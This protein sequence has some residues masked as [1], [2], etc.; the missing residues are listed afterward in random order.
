MYIYIYYATICG[1]DGGKGVSQNHGA[2]NDRHR[3]HPP[4]KQTDTQVDFGTPT[5]YYMC[6]KLG[7][8]ILHSLMP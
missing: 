8:I 5:C 7:E 1:F 3:R 6:S 4:E 2:P